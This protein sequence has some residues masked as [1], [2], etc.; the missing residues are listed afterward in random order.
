MK[1]AKI[2]KHKEYSQ[3]KL[4]RS[5]VT[6]EEDDGTEGHDDEANQQV[7]HSQ[8]HQEVV[9]HVLELPGL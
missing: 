5:K 4:I 9:G 1:K 2:L 7:R 3:V 6:G 8:G